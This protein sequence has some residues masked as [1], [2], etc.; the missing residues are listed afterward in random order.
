MPTRTKIEYY[1]G[2]GYLFNIGI[3]EKIETIYGVELKYMHNPRVISFILDPNA[4]LQNLS[5][6][7]LDNNRAVKYYDRQDP[8][9]APDLSNSLTFVRLVL[10]DL[11]VKSGQAKK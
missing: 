7:N 2:R 10:E 9:S 11:E 8:E 5:T 6:A 3:P 1:P 4:A